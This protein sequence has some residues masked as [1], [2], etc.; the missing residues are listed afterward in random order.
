MKLF[1]YNFSA[2][3]DRYFFDELYVTA[4]NRASARDAPTFLCVESSLTEQYFLLS[5]NGHPKI[6]ATV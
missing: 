3:F 5:F 2:H 1:S 6:A 4:E